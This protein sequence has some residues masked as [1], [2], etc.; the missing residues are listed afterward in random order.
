MIGKRDQK[1]NRM[2]RREEVPLKPPDS[3]ENWDGFGAPTPN[4][5]LSSLPVAIPSHGWR[6]NSPAPT[7][8]VFQE[9]LGGAER[10]W[11]ALESRERAAAATGIHGAGGTNVP[12]K[13]QDP[14]ADPAAS[15]NPYFLRN[16][17]ILV[18]ICS[19]SPVEMWWP[20]PGS[21]TCRWPRHSSFAQRQNPWDYPGL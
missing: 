10:E 5:Q 2:E 8:G 9:R 13:S 4:S 16:K 14:R 12:G 1:E 19:C 20:R 11:K 6:G 15:Q 21:L 7:P 3:G 18:P 17:S